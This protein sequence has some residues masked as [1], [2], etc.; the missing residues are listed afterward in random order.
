MFIMKVQEEEKQKDLGKYSILKILDSALAN[1]Q[2][3]LIVARELLAVALMMNM[4][5]CSFSL[6]EITISDPDVCQ[7]V[8]ENQN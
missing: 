2:D 5:D 1:S 4:E 8:F 3:G 7:K 6:R